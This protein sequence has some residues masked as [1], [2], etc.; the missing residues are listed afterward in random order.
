M[1][2]IRI[3]LGVGPDTLKGVVRHHLPPQYKF[4]RKEINIDDPYDGSKL[5]STIPGACRIILGS[6]HLDHHDVI[7]LLVERQNYLQHQV[8][9]AQHKKQRMWHLTIVY[10]QPNII[11]DTSIL[12]LN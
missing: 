9:K 5:F 6:T 2:H 10:L 1:R 3:A 8:W 12:C 4:S 11:G 7:N